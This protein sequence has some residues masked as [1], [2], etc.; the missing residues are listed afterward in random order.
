MRETLVVV[1][2]PGYTPEVGAA[3]W[4]LE[5]TRERTL[6]LLRE[7]PPAYVD[8]E[9]EGNQ[10]GTILYHLALIEADWLY[11]EIL[12]APYSDAAKQLLPADHRDAEG[13]L[14]LSQ[15]ETLDQHLA[16][17]RSIRVLFLEGLRE[18]TDEEFHRPRSLPSYEV[19]PAWVLHHLSQHEAEHRGEIGSIIERFKRNR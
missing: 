16:R 5:N 17:L 10:I 9:S 2:L 13:I 19:S 6:R 3:L 11:T 8:Q 7:L 4:R 12:E 15:G 18:M 14:T 1:G